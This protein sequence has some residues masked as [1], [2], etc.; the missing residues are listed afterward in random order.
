MKLN[1]NKIY[2]III[3]IFIYYITTFYEKNTCINDNYLEYYLSKNKL[4]KKIYKSILTSNK[5]FY[6]DQKIKLIELIK[7]EKPTEQLSIINHLKN[8]LN[9]NRY[10]DIYNDYIINENTTLGSI[11]NTWL[12]DNILNNLIC[13]IDKKKNRNYK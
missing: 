12:Q 13:E 11:R 2:V 10:H 3:M 4:K 7:N 6:A 8:I 5:N 9:N 1:Y